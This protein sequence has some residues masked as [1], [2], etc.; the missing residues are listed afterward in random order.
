[1]V[2]SAEINENSMN[3]NRTADSFLIVV[4][5]KCRR[6]KSMEQLVGYGRDTEVSVK[7][8]EISKIPFH[9]PVQLSLL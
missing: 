7:G 1:M 3:A 5:F 2:L 9:Y 6:V 4:S 8:K